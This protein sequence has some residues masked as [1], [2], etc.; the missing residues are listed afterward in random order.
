LP[1]KTPPNTSVNK[2]SAITVGLKIALT[3]PLWK[4]GFTLKVLPEGDTGGFACPAVQDFGW[5][6]IHLNLPLL[7]GETRLKADRNENKIG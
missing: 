7:K 5:R 6:E 4:K 3:L 1:E 2:N